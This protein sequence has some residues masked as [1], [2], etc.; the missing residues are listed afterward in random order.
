MVHCR[1]EI[2]SVIVLPGCSCSGAATVPERVQEFV[3]EENTADAQFLWST[4]Y[5][6][7]VEM[8]FG[9]LRFLLLV[10]V[11]LSEVR[12]RVS[13]CCVRL[14]FMILSFVCLCRFI[15]V[16]SCLV[17]S[18]FS[19]IPA[20]QDVSSYCLLILVRDWTNIHR[21]SFSTNKTPAAKCQNVFFPRGHIS[22]PFTLFP[23]PLQTTAWAINWLVHVSVTV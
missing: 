14:V 7:P 12:P 6:W 5:L 21:K 17:L 22:L 13:L 11:V 2:S 10:S 15:L 16:F 19:T 23:S 8:M 9:N 3:A 18:V 20:H 1:E 4:A